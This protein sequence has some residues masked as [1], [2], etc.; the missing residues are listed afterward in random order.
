MRLF[1]IWP[2]SSRQVKYQ[3]RGAYERPHCCVVVFLCTPF[4]FVK[5]ACRYAIVPLKIMV[6]NG[7]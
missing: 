2:L 5:P 6:Y 4:F 7:L 3:K 1:L